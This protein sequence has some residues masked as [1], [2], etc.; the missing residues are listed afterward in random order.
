MEAWLY[1]L[2]ED[3]CFA[4]IFVQNRYFSSCYIFSLKAWS[5]SIS[6]RRTQ[7]QNF[8]FLLWEETEKS[9]QLI[10]DSTW[11][12]PLFSLAPSSCMHS[13]G[14]THWYKDGYI[15][16]YIKNIGKNSFSK[17]IFFKEFLLNF[18]HFW[19]LRP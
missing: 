5:C 6:L 15:H 2:L 14:N 18:K 3:S 16:P 9:V 8:I 7:T 13:L 10:Q 11:W 4:F 1:A 17:K 12:F 19:L